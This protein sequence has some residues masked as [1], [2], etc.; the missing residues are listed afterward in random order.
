MPRWSHDG[1]ELFYFTPDG[2]LRALPVTAT[3]SSL[4]AGPPKSLFRA[5]VGQPLTSAR[6]SVS[7]DGRFLVRT[8]GVELSITVVLNWQEELKQ[9]VP[10][11]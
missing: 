3:A 8:L 7:S 1:K 4:E 2:T 6:Y 5:N 10:T 9:R 11:R